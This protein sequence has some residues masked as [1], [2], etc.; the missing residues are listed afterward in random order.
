VNVTLDVLSQFLA[1]HRASPNSVTII[2]DRTDGR[3]IAASEQNKGVRMIDGHLQ[4]ARLQNMADEDVREAYRLQT[5]TGRDNIVFASPRNGQE[6]SA[7]FSPFPD[8]FGRPW[9]AVILTP[10]DDFIGQLKATNRQ[11]VIVIVLLTALELLLIHFLSRR[12]SKPI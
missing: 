1:T 4:I 8:R 7:S 6:I 9:E 3:V 12:L 2:A 5:Q 10:T 11:I